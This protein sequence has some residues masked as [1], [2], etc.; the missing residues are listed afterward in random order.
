MYIYD[1]PSAQNR[2]VFKRKLFSEE[3]NVSLDFV[4]RQAASFLINVTRM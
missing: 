3:R 2:L 1:F 4:E